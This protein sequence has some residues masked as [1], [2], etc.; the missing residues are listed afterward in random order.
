MQ[1]DPIRIVIAGGGTAGWMTAAALGRFLGEG[2]TVRLIESDEIGTVGVGESTIPQVRLFN[3]AL[4]IDEDEFLAAAQGSYKLGIEFVGW[5]APGHRYMHA[6]GD[7]GRDVGLV[8]FQ[9][10]WRRAKDLGF[11]KPLSHYSLN[12][13]A[14]RAGRMHRGGPI[15]ARIIPPLPYAFHIDAGLYAVYLRRFAEALGVRRTEGRIAEVERHGANVRALRLAS[16]EKI[17]A[18]LFIDCTG[19]RALLIDSDYEDWSHSLPCGRA[20]VQG[21]ARGAWCARSS[22]Q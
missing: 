12:E 19:F 1:D 13:M 21:R 5:R 15:T 3:Q 8:P 6:F 7:I 11:A 18:D 22:S 4:G 2:F 17:E 14:A 20:A 9:H 16:G 10:Y